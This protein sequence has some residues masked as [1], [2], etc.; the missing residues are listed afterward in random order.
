MEMKKSCWD[1]KR[2]SLLGCL[3]ILALFAAVPGY[4]TL[5]DRGGGLIYDDVLKVTWLQDANYA[6]TSGYHAT[7]RMNW[8]EAV[9]WA[10]GLSYYDP[11]RGVTWND[12]RLPHV[13]PVNG[14]SYDFNSSF[15]GSTDNGYNISSPGSAYPGS[16]GSEL[17]FMFYN[18]LINKGMYDVNGNTP[19]P[20]WGLKNTGPFIGFPTPTYPIF[21]TGLD[22]GAPG[23]DW[24]WGFNLQQGFQ[25]SGTK[26]NLYYAWAVRDGDVG[27]QAIPGL[28]NTGVNDSNALLP[29][30]AIDP[31]YVLTVS[32]DLSFPSWAMLGDRYPIAAGPWISNGPDSKWIG[33][34][35]NGLDGSAAGY[36]TYRTTFD[37]TE[38]DPASASIVGRWTMDNNA[39]DILINGVSTGIKSPPPPD[40]FTQ[41]YTFT[42]N[43]GFVT[44]LNTLDFLVYNVPDVVDTPT[45]LRVELSGKA[46]AA[47]EPSPPTAKCHDVTVA[48][49]S[50][51]T[52]NASIDN[53]SY[54]PNGNP[55]TLTQT[56]E[57]PYQLGTTP[58]TL[59]VTDSNNPSSQSQCTGTVNVV[60]ST[61]PTI[62][63]A[64]ASPS[65]LWPPNSKMVDVDI[66]YNHTDNCSSSQ[67]ITCQLGVTSNERISTSDYAIMNAHHVRLRAERLG[68]GSVRAYAITITCT[69]AAGKSSS[70]AVMVDVPHDQGKK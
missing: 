62:D 43:S 6:K 55:V 48:A 29:D 47:A 36:Y 53:G 41:W 49:G 1:K 40:V 32:P 31:H 35:A 46:N 63:Y 5:W 19:Q 13:L 8:D 67:N 14:S 61:P 7:G 51:C 56:P 17:A 57:E 11:V 4:A 37:L 30:G 64:S 68:G 58:V 34:I 59:T 65:V 39:T 2:L 66:N 54:G 10:N 60:D 33:P 15:N 20:D 9:A 26:A 24:A 25:N 21:W 70:Q 18:N 23:A 3:S 27:G 22:Y 16:T 45:G 28:F 44:G 69:D 12:W 50:T 42:I 38:L 52:A